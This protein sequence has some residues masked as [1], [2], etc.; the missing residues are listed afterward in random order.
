VTDPN[1]ENELA[2]FRQFAAAARSL[3]IE[4]GSIEKRPPPEPD[5]RYDDRNGA[6]AMELV[7]LLDEEVA[8]DQG[9]AARLQNA[10]TSAL[11]S[12]QVLTLRGRLVRVRFLDELSLSRKIAAVPNIVELLASL[13]EGY[14][15]DV[16]A[17]GAAKIDVHRWAEGSEVMAAVYAGGGWI[18]PVSTD[19]VAAKLQKVYVTD[20]PIGLLAYYQRQ[21]VS[22]ELWAHP[23]LCN[24]IE[25]GLAGSPF[26]RG[27]IFDTWSGQVLFSH[28]L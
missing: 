19:K 14:L 5:I 3:G 10:L 28:P 18:S 11:G 24:L 9:D 6:H 4:T 7:E 17:P 23:E 2:V 25:T 22:A 16:S 21:P 26:G 1:T 13:P 12:R 27:W 8:R 20:S 15:G